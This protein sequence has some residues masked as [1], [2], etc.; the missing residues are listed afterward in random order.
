MKGFQPHSSRLFTILL[1]GLV[2]L[3]GLLAEYQL[4]ER[5]QPTPLQVPVHEQ[6][7]SA[8]PVR[9]DGPLHEVSERARVASANRP[10]WVF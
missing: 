10:R 7:S 2:V 4:R 8:P 3:L 6:S 1:V 5:I 9:A